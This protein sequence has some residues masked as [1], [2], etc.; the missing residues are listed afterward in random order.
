MTSEA[1]QQVEEY[2]DRLRERL[3]GLHADDIREIVEELR[4]HIL[5]KAASSGQVTPAG[6]AA[7]LA[8]LGSPERLAGEY[9]TDSLLAQA[10]VSRT[11]W[12]IF[13]A[14]F[15]WASLSVAGFLVLL[16]SIAGYFF[17]A[18]FAL[19]AVLKP[20]HP[21]TAGLWL[22]PDPAGD[23]QV[24]LRLGFEGAP[25]AGRELLG[26]WIV[27]IGLVTSCLMVIVTTSFCSWCVRQYRRSHLLPRR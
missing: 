1:Q 20:I 18:V 4:S 24:S 11:P 26:W 19:C 2:L 25:I 9:V 13:D 21:H 6:V 12:R 10:E 7:A 15:R 14:L 8:G 27:P 16:G 17:G 22:I 3:R 5:E 23:L